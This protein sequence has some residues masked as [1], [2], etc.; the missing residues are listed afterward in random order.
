MLHR[1]F[2]DCKKKLTRPFG[3][4]RVSERC[5]KHKK[6]AKLKQV[7]ESHEKNKAL[8]KKL[9][10]EKRLELLSKRKSKV[11]SKKLSKAVKNRRANYCINH[12]PKKDC[13]ECNEFVGIFKHVDPKAMIMMLE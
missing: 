7:M 6:E 13:W 12:C 2:L 4:S 5:D 10:Q 3:S 1:E 9:K 8:K 11:L